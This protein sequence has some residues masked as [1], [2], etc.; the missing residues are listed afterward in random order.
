M[1]FMN[2]NVNLLQ[3][4]VRYTIYIPTN[5]LILLHWSTGLHKETDTAHNSNVHVNDARY[6]YYILYNILYIYWLC[7]RFMQKEHMSVVY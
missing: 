6:I 2:Q 1:K 5:Y 7:K 3:S 4:C